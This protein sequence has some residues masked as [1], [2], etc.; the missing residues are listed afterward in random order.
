MEKKSP[1]GTGV[2]S[3]VTFAFL[4][5]LCA[6][7]FAVA[8]DATINFFGA[9]MHGL[10]LNTVRSAAPLSLGR[11]LYGVI[12]LAIIGFIT[13]LVFAWTYNAVNRK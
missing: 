3:A 7:A 6:I 4:S 10:D 8:P 5:I 11:V 12:G 2:V 9:F 13:G 1:L